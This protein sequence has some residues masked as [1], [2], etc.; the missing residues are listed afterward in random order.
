M[1]P[2]PDAQIAA[3]RGFNRF[4]TRAIGLLGHYLGGPWSL[5]EARVLYELFT[6]DGLT[7]RDLG[8]ELGLDAGY[9]SRI[10][11]RFE[12]DG[13]LVRSPAPEDGRRQ[14]LALTAAGRAAFAPYDQASRDEVAGLLARLGPADRDRL[15]GAMTEIQGVMAGEGAAVTIRRHRL[16]DM[17][18]IIA[19]QARVYA[20]EYG[21]NDEFEALAAEIG[22]AFLKSNDPAR[23]RAFIAER[24]GEVVGSVFCVDGGEGVA[25]LRMLYVDASTRGTGLGKRLV[26][27]C[28]AFAREA[29]YRGMTLWTND[30]LTAARGIYVAEG[31][32]LASE[33]RH[34]SFGVDLVG[35]NWTLDF[36]AS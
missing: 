36:G 15:V 8:A 14:V 9:L 35:Q 32:V 19:G 17:G 22:A 6:R 33:E 26:A 28:I 13:L 31:F 10:L 23:E 16:G 12:R 4:Y 1:S 30:C 2:S 7:A 11:G 25:K 27:E 3:I 34:Q 18:A 21:W 29:G 5:T 24:R 20:T